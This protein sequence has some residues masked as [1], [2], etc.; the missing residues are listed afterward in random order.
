MTQGQRSWA[1][2]VL[3]EVDDLHISFDTPSGPVYAVNG[4]SLQLRRGEMLSIL[5]ESGC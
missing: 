3:L 2:N 1:G 4:V 5:G